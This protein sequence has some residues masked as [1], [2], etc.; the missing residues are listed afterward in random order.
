MAEHEVF[1][2]ICIKNTDITSVPPSF[3]QQ[4]H[5]E[6]L[7]LGCNG[8]NT[9][10]KGTYDLPSVRT[11]DFSGNKLTGAAFEGVSWSVDALEHLNLSENHIEKLFIPISH[12]KGRSPVLKT[13][14]VAG[15]RLSG[16][17]SAFNGVLDGLEELNISWNRFGKI[18]P[19]IV[20]FESVKI[21][22]ADG[23]ELNE[24]PGEF[25]HWGI[26]EC[27]LSHN[28][29][30]KIP[31]CLLQ[32]PRLERLNLSH[33]GMTVRGPEPKLKGNDKCWGLRISEGNTVL[34]PRF[35]LAQLLIDLYSYTLAPIFQAIGS[36]FTYCC[37][38]VY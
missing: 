29:F 19:G 33:N 12:N 37:E 1:E 35:F 38:M 10:P 17:P 9:L 20:N 15:N 34:P 21:F 2:K 8:L 26:E 30:T 24:L 36:L 16:L 5:L 23:N 28:K 32:A 4:K 14:N 25:M 13:L 7:N 22:L 31:D 18:V 27:S 6:Y 3:F 11:I